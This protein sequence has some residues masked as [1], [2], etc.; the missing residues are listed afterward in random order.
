MVIKGCR[1][2]AEWRLENVYV[3]TDMI[4]SSDRNTSLQRGEYRKGV[5][6]NE[7]D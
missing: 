2:L 6:E 5:V 4:D 7:I 1:S 3:E